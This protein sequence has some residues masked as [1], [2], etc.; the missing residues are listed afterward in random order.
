MTNLRSDISRIMDYRE[1]CARCI[2]GSEVDKQGQ[3]EEAC[4]EVDKVG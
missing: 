1:S 4:S 2:V 3:M